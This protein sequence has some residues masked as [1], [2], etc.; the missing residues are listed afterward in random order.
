MKV[1]PEGSK[2]HQRDDWED[3]AAGYRD[4][5]YNCDLPKR[6]VADIDQ[7]E[8]RFNNYG[9]LEYI[10]LLELTRVDGEWV[11]DAYLDAIV[12]RFDRDGQAFC[13]E[14]VAERLRCDAWIVLFRKDL[15]E[16][17][18]YN[19]SRRRGWYKSLSQ[20]Q[21]KKWLDNNCGRS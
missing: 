16:F 19:L 5:R 11:A 8:Y 17:W 20:D 21:Y 12:A 15:T 18:L 6:Y 10:A 14:A 7:I 13:A 1:T 3:R 9:K 4:W 2:D